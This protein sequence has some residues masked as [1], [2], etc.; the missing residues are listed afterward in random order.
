MSG[1]LQDFRYALRLLR[2]SPGFTI[3]ALG[4]LAL[5]I[6]ANTA[7]FS[8]VNAILLR[9]MPVSE[10]EALVAVFQAD[11]Q[12]PGTIPMSHLNFEDVRAMNTTLSGL[13]AVSFGQ[14]NVRVASG[15]SSQILIQIVS[16]NYFDVMGVALER[17]RGFQPQEDQADGAYPVAVLSWGFWQRQLGGDPDAVGSSITL[18]RVPFTVVGVTPR[19]FTGTFPV[20]PDAWVPTAMHAVAQPEMAWYEQRRGAFLFPV[21]RLKP[22]VTVDQARGNLQA[23][24]ARLA[25]E[26]PVDNQG[27]ASA[28]VQPLIEARVNPGGQGIIL[29]TSR[30]LLGVVGLVLLIACANLASLQLARGSRRQKELAVR[31]AVG[32]NRRRIVRQLLTESVTLSVAGG[33]LGLVVA[34][35]MLRA[36]AAAST[37]LPVPIDE[38]IVSLDA[39]VL[40]FVALVSVATGILFGVLPA[41]Q[42]SRTNVVGTIK[43]EVLSGEGRGWLRKSVVAAQVALSVV[44]LVAAGLFLRSMD[45]TVMIDPGFDSSNVT[46]VAFNL[47]REGYDVERGGLFYRQAVERAGAIPGVESAAVAESIPLAGVQ[48]QRTVYL[49]A[50]PPP[51]E[52]RRMAFVNYVSPGYFETTRIPLLRGRA[53]DQRDAVDSPSVAVINESMAA[54]FWPDEDALGKRFWFFGETE[55]TEVVGIARDSKVAF[56]AENPQPLAYEPMYQDYRTFGALIV[57]TGGPTSGIGTMLRGAIGEIDPD[58]TILNVRTLDEQV[59][60]SLAGQQ[61]LTSLIGVFGVVALL[62]SAMGVY[63]VASHWVSHRTREIGLRMAL[64]AR[65]GRLLALVMRQ[66]LTVVGIGLAAGTLAAG[67]AAALLGPQISTLL[68]EISP[69]DPPTF[70]G[71]IG[72]LV[73]VGALACLVPARR[74]AR[75][76]PLRALRQD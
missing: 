50:T 11:E 13:A 27:R 4:S 36:L 8:L 25:E 24:M 35:A 2:R 55:P 67:L 46:T 70:A 21:G 42:S 1:W 45:R 28:E 30:L 61:T 69:T 19:T 38:S 18:N 12:T 10:P 74:A 39:R 14:A 47:G 53:F 22:G 71:T 5:G 57:R 9:P 40:S 37:A 16:G 64:G 31:L 54:R 48:I 23:V 3:V 59:R 75:I 33:A 58:L 72:I 66:S 63:G 60:A 65:P 32:A 7:I 73:T 52:G 29:A 68:V 76:D 41:L 56:L 49:T 26:Y 51:D 6:G 44:S 34:V 20:G 17:G 43:Q 62:L 15:E